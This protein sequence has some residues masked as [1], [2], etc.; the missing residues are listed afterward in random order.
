M[1]RSG[2]PL[3][4]PD[5]SHSVFIDGVADLCKSPND[6]IE[7]FAL[8]EHLAHL[9]IAYACPL[10]LVLHENPSGLETGK[11]RGHLGSQLERKAES[12]LRIARD[13]KSGASIFF[14]SAAAT[15]ASPA[16]TPSASPGPCPTAC[17]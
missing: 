8:V 12:N 10:I 13:G 4:K 5:L 1:L 2:T 17:T 14:P 3:C 16:T 15:P 9:A 6:D 11:T 7:A